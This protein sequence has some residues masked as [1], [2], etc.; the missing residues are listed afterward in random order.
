MPSLSTHRTIAPMQFNV[1]EIPMF[2]NQPD[3]YTAYLAMFRRALDDEIE[4]AQ[5]SARGRTFITD[6]RYLGTREGLAIYSFTADTELRFPDGSFVT[7]SY[8]DQQ[9]AGQIVSIDGF[10]LVIA[11][12]QSYGDQIPSATLSASPWMLLRELQRRLEE[13]AEQRQPL[14][15]QV[16][17]NTGT[18]R[19]PD[20]NQATELLDRIG[21]HDAAPLDANL[22][23]RQAIAHILSNRIS[24]VW[25]PPGT[26]KTK[27][28]GMTVAA[29]VESGQSVLVVAHSNVA[30]DVAMLSVA[31]Y[32]HH[33]QAY[34]TGSIL[35]YGV[36]ALAD[37]D[38]FP[39]L[40]VKGV[41]R[42]KHRV[43]IERLE[44]LDAER[45]RLTKLSRDPE[46]E[47]GKREAIK[48]MLAKVKQDLTPLQAELREKE[49]ELL[50]WASVVGCTLS[51]AA[52]ASEI[53]Q[54]QFDAVLLD[55]ASM[56]YI[57]QCVFATNLARQR[58]AFFGDFRQLPPVSQADTDSAKRWLQRDIFD[59]A[60][61]I[62]RVQRGQ[63]DPQ[64]VLL[65]TQYRMHPEISA[66]INELFYAGLLRDSPTVEQATAAIVR[67]NPNKGHALALYDLKLLSAFCL[68]EHEAFS[69]F[70]PISALVAVHFAHN[71]LR[72]GNLRVGIITPY[73]AQSRLIRRLVQDV[74]LPSERVAVAT[75]HRFQGSECDAVIFDIVEGPPKTKAGRLIVGGTRSTAM[76]LANVAISRARGKFIGLVHHTYLHEQLAQTDSFRQLIDHIAAHIQPK[77]VGW[78]DRVAS[79]WEGTF[80]NWA[81]YSNVEGARTDLEQNLRSAQEEI[82]VVW[83]DVPLPIAKGMLAGSPG[84]V[85]LFVAGPRRE[86]LGSGIRNSYVWDGHAKPTVGMIGID[87][88]QLWLFLAPH[89]ADGPVL[90]F[91]WTQTVKLLYAFLRLV[92]AREV[93]RST[94]NEKLEEGQS[95][96]GLPCERCGQPMWPDT[97]PYGAYMTCAAGCGFKRRLDIEDAT[98]LARMMDVMCEACGSQIVGRKSHKGV[99]LGC[100]RYP[101]CGWMKA[102]E[103]VI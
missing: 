63:R 31:R 84:G 47:V 44:A 54:R 96:V 98:A 89:K 9:C 93:K 12:D 55:E 19:A 45:R 53:Y 82:A 46:L 61:L 58:V 27:T 65:A 87:R 67:R 90:R 75:V 20:I 94:L 51:K 8:R 42:E 78:P 56:A 10:D 25:G 88:K 1:K 66:T 32:L 59:H 34:R 86:Q 21:G 33:S 40:Y 38:T 24:F 101:A 60:G 77:S 15:E 7:V 13:I 92:P 6:G 62:E 97:G 43:F 3:P 73:N 52:L 57:P 76:R 74:G 30:V 100:V 26:G 91:D 39:H 83:P 36:P 102:I 35:R 69:R 71:L 17:L 14:V 2:A 72:K 99:L 22:H 41:L 79:F 28:L 48:D 5:S 85:R 4:A 37:L 64:L 29:L 23:Q 68:S 50:R 49:R 70:N 18:H 16:V 80:Q 103:Q 81:Y 95:P 11:L